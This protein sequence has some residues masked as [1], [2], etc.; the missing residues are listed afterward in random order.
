VNLED[1]VLAVLATLNRLAV[2]YM[3][4]G[5]FSSNTYGIPRATHDADFVVQVEP[6]GV[7]RIVEQ[8]GPQFRLEP[9]ITFE[10]TTATTRF[11]VELTGSAFTIEFF[12]LSDDPHDQQRFARRREVEL[13][14]HRAVATMPS[15]E[16][17]IITK[18]RWFKNGRRARDFD[19][20]RGI[21]A[22]RGDRLDWGYLHHWSDLHGTR[23]LL[24]QVRAS[25][26]PA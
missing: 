6:G 17:V 18:L 25:I 12:L 2:P 23:E 24:E 10:T 8:L 14:G 21:V 20:V 1:A 5:S 22:V 9:Q 11:V 19:D 15:P 4:V 16:D 7:R 3:L 13:P 26:P